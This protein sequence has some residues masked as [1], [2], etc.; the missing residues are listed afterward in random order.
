MGVASTDGGHG[1]KIFMH[2]YINC[3]PNLQCFPMP[4]MGAEREK[5]EYSGSR[6]TH[7]ANPV[8]FYHT[9]YRS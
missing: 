8:P 7:I 1:R 2:D 5:E 9:L 6:A 3:P 4:M